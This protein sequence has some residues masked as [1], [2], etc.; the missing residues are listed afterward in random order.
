MST[1]N[2]NGMASAAPMASSFQPVEYICDVCGKSCRSKAGLTIHRNVHPSSTH[3][4]QPR[5][6]PSNVPCARSHFTRKWDSRST[7]DTAT[8]KNNGEKR[9][10]MVTSVRSR[11][12]TES[13]KKRLQHLDWQY[14][15]DVL[16]DSISSDDGT[17]P[18]YLSSDF[19]HTL[20][21]FPNCST[22]LAPDAPQPTV[23]LS[24]T[25]IGLL[26]A[27]CSL[28]RS[29]PHDV[30]GSV[31]LLSIEEAALSQSVDIATLRCR[32]ETHADANIPH[33]WNPSRPRSSRVPPR[34]TSGRQRKPPRPKILARRAQYAHLQCLF[35]QRKKD[36]AKKVIS[37]RWRSAHTNDC[38]WSPDFTRF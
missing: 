23:N 38:S 20:Q 25:S 27:A 21:P 14:P 12:S 19:T 18:S 1:H 24:A 35:A 13:I 2:A 33:L 37:G 16:P 30:F 8:S 32:L 11:R 17:D 4:P 9:Q 10:Q 15:G 6:R 36:A 31:E 3:P 29:T 7:R 28:L 22:D 5:P 34:P 26:E